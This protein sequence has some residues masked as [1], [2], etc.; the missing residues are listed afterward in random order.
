VRARSRRRVPWA[1]RL[2]IC[3]GASAPALSPCAAR[4]APPARPSPAVAVT[5][6]NAFGFELYARLTAGQKNVI[7]SPVSASIALTMAWAGARGDTEREMARA[8]SLEATE[9]EAT[10]AAFGALL[11]VLNK[12]NGREDV[13]LQVADRLWGQKDVDFEPQYLELLAGRYRAPLEKVDFVNATEKARVAINRWAAAKTHNR[14]REVLHPGDVH[15]ET[16][17]VL[18]NAVYLKAGWQAEFAKGATVDGPFTAPTGKVVAKMMHLQASFNY[19]RAPGARI[20][21]LGYKGDL[22][23]VIVLPD[24]K[25][26]LAAVEG[27]LAASYAGWLKALRFKRIDLELPRWTIRSRLDL[28]GVLGAMGMASAFTTA[29]D[30][31]GMSS[32]RRL[33]I[34]KVLQEAFVNVD[35]DGTEAAAVTAVLMRAV[36]AMVYR[37]EPIPFHVDHPFLY[38]IRDKNTGA[39]LFIGRVVDPR[40]P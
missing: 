32:Q 9:R 40:G 39:V 17:L 33:F 38:L 13:T 30:F 22:S 24:A 8:L 18:T 36:S 34:D 19:A 31:S 3:L 25:D 26:G 37:D 2:A 7:C 21:E 11:D 14:I 5:A 29:A 23:M 6:S 15:V 4:A 28:G 27:R 10:H 1:A 12:R 16:R 35:E 20:L